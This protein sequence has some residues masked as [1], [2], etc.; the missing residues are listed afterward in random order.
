MSSFYV[1]NK[2]KF[3]NI[4]CLQNIYNMC[5]NTNRK[6]QFAIDCYLHPV[7]LYALIPLFGNNNVI[8]AIFLN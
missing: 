7:I 2:H 3:L 5:E 4:Y 6:V 8:A 1:V